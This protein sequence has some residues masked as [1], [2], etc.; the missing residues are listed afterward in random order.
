[1]KACGILKGEKTFTLYNI[2]SICVYNISSSMISEN[3]QCLKIIPK[4]WKLSYLLIIKTLIIC[5]MIQK[6][7]NHLILLALD[8]TATFSFLMWKLISELCKNVSKVE[9]LKILPKTFWIS[10]KPRIFFLT[11]LYVITLYISVSKSPI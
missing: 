8:I 1:M 5:S 9:F 3:A 11:I 4:Y 2:S 7:W 6:L 10:G